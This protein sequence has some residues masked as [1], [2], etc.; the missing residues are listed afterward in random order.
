MTDTRLAN[1]RHAITKNK[2]QILSALPAGVDKNRLLSVYMSAAMTSGKNGAAGVVDCHPLSIV[3]AVI[4]AAQFGLS[5]EGISGEA[6]LVPRWD[7][8]MKGHLCTMQIGYKGLRKLAR[9]GDPDL[10]DVF[11]YPVYK[12]DTFTWK[13]GIEPTIEVHTPAPYSPNRT[14]VAAYAVA[15]WKDGYRRFFVA[16][17]GHI[18][19]AMNS[20]GNSKGPS[21]LWKQHPEA[22]WMKTA[23]RRL[24]GTLNLS[25]DVQGQL[26]TDGFDGMQLL[27]AAGAAGRVVASEAGYGSDV[28]NTTTE[29]V[30]YEED[31]PA[32]SADPLTQAAE[33]AAPEA[34]LDPEEIERATRDLQAPP[35]V[36]ESPAPAAERAPRQRR[37]LNVPAETPEEEPSA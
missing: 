5:L 3:G 35:P 9:Q 33:A 32:P 1:V 23:M 2:N 28:L 7:K 29:V 30:G 27:K 26:E 15:V 18:R 16:D 22:M 20:S 17:E 25:S 13:L 14:L 12:E 10:R 19:V 36:T 11:A 21:P 4:R 8:H 6:Y 37:K 31:S 24:C 34:D